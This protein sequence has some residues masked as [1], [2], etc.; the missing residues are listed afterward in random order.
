MLPI[1]AG[2]GA[3]I[4]GAGSVE[5]RRVVRASAA[6][7]TLAVGITEDVH[8]LVDPD[9]GP[10][11]VGTR[12]GAKVVTFC[13]IAAHLAPPGPKPREL[14]RRAPVELLPSSRPGEP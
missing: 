2:T 10:S 13:L 9:S 4:I 5:V 1:V 3:K 8:I 6:F 7:A 14:S 11:G 12:W